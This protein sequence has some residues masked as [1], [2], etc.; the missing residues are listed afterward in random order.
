[1][2]GLTNPPG[3]LIRPEE[4]REEVRGIGTNTRY[5]RNVLP[6]SAPAECLQVV[7]V[8]TP[9][10]HWSSYPPHKHD[11]AQPGET[12]WGLRISAPLHG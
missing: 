9:G 3:V 2:A 11:S 6:A 1:M 10:G 12:P 8:L 7:E 4:L 5:V